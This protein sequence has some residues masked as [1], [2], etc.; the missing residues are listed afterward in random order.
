M[1]RSV[2]DTDLTI[3]A[4]IRLAVSSSRFVGIA[5]NGSPAFNLELTGRG[6]PT[7]AGGAAI[8]T[9]TSM[10]IKRL[11]AASPQ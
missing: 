7:G 9:F 11:C 2:Y 10:P 5:R 1:C 8:Q 4:E 6:H 3:K